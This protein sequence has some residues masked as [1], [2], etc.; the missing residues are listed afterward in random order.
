MQQ[1]KNHQEVKQQIKIVILGARCRHS[2]MHNC[3]VAAT[4]GIN[5]IS[6]KVCLDTSLHRENE[7]ETRNLNYSVRHIIQLVS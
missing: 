6:C 2:C 3:D 4:L 7:K 1:K 5:V